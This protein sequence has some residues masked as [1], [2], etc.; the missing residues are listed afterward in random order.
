MAVLEANWALGLDHKSTRM[1]LVHPQEFIELNHSDESVSIDAAT[2]VP[3]RTFA[4]NR[5]RL[6]NHYVNLFPWAIEQLSNGHSNWEFASA[7]HTPFFDVLERT[8]V[9]IRTPFTP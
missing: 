4:T 2:E 9:P 5:H 3:K 8:G 1:A 7:V 6:T